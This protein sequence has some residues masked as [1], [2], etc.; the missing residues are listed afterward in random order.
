MR[1]LVEAVVTSVWSDFVVPYVG[2]RAPHA[3]RE[4]GMFLA[5]L[6][7]SSPWEAVV[8]QLEGNRARKQQRD[9]L[10]TSCHLRSASVFRPD[11]AEVVWR[12][13]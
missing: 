4:E 12:P 10:V 5:R 11:L 7:T 3:P 1:Q 8:R 9:D 13:Q 2:A 6:Q